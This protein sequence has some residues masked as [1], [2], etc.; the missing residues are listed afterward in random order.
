MLSKSAAIILGIVQERPLN[1]YELIKVLSTLRTKDWYEIADSTVYATLKSLEKRSFLSGE[2]KKDGNMPDKTVYSIT[3]DGEVALKETLEAF[4]SEFQY[5]LVPFMI[6]GFFFKVLGKS[7]ALDCLE[8]R[9]VFLKKS[10]D[11]IA[12]RLKVI[13]NEGVPQYVLCDVEHSYLIVQSEI[14]AT[15][16]MIKALSLDENWR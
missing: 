11:G 7:T 15:E 9:L 16:K 6:A 12:E 3:C 5:D 2:I 8:K 13:G 4:I 14:T 10:S 1:A